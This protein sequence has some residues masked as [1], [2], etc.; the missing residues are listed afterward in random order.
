MQI[1]KAA[2]EDTRGPK[3]DDVFAPLDEAERVQILELF[4][5][6]GGLETEIEVAEALDRRES[7][8]AHRRL[9]AALI[10]QGDVTA[11]DFANRLA[12][13]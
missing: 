4:A 8:T 6:D 3:D 1:D 11:E 10:S 2:S 13:R 12:R 5:R 7:R 9:Q